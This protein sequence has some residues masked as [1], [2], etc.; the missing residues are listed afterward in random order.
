[1]SYA[2]ILYRE[3]R[4]GRKTTTILIF[5]GTLFG[6]LAGVTAIVDILPLWLSIVPGIVGFAALGAGYSRWRH[7]DDRAYELL[8][9]ASREGADDVVTA[10]LNDG[11]SVNGA[12][13][14]GFTPLL[15]A[16]WKTR[17]KTIAL[18]LDRGADINQGL[19]RSVIFEDNA[20]SS[21]GK[22]CWLDAGTTPL[23]MACAKGTKRSIRKF[24][25]R[26]ADA[27]LH[28]VNGLSA[29][30][31]I[32][33]WGQP[34]DFLPLLIANGATIS[35]DSRVLL[36]KEQDLPPEL[37]RLVPVAETEDNNGKP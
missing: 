3:L 34:L 36:S 20:M 16:T 13:R 24:L 9:T 12:D 8:V 6:P 14:Q 17:L 10:I 28:D 35:Q 15:A 7:Y 27:S 22:P 4:A 26:G 2:D 21:S 31:L 29:I 18:L 25:D 33:T 23:M 5:C 37:L 32:V 19:G 30:D 1:M 11:F